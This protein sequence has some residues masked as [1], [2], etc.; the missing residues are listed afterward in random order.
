[1][2]SIG[3]EENSMRPKL[4]LVGAERAKHLNNV[5][6]IKAYPVNA[7]KPLRITGPGIMRFAKTSIVA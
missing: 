7:T 2:V 5:K 6:E 4:T 1:M 3:A